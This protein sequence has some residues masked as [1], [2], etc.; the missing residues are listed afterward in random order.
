M[1]KYLFGL[2]AGIV[3]STSVLAQSQWKEGTHYKVIKPQASAKPVIKEVFSF[4]CPAC[5]NFE[6]I[7]AQL[8][9]QLPENV[10]FNKVHANFMGYVSKDIQNDVSKAM[11]AAR[12]MK[13][14]ARFN[15]A[16]FNA[17]HRERKPITGMDD[18]TDVYKIAGGD[19]D[20]MKKLVNSFGIKSQLNRNIKATKGFSSVPTFVVNDKYQATFTRDM[21]PDQYV[22]LLKWLSTQK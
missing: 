12:A 11:L 2:A 19:A 8:K 20:K 3:L 10:E 13:D 22:A 17:I 21:S 5:F 1:I 18:V 16:M 6:T 4:W 15:Q 7:V 9:K 14:E